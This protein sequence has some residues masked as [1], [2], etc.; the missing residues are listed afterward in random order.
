MYSRID[1]LFCWLPKFHRPVIEIRKSSSLAI[2]TLENRIVPDGQG[3]SHLLPEWN[4][5]QWLNPPASVAPLSSSVLVPL[6]AP[7]PPS[8]GSGA[9]PSDFSQFHF[10][11]TLP[12]E[13]I[14]PALSASVLTGNYQRHYTL[15]AQRPGKQVFLDVQI[16]SAVQFGSNSVTESGTLTVSK[17][18]QQ[19]GSLTSQ[20]IASVIPFSQTVPEDTHGL[21]YFGLGGGNGVSGYTASVLLDSQTTWNQVLWSDSAAFLTNGSWTFSDNTSFGQCLIDQSS[22]S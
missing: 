18:V 22:L 14:T 12:A 20:I 2:E 3:F 11:T 15:N 6:E 1:F 7:V 16:V 17:T 13:T 8:Y 21:H 10:P 5:D 19:N 4:G 9:V